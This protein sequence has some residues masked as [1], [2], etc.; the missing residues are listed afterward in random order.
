M[1]FWDTVL[2]GFLGSLAAGLILVLLYVV[3]QWF[4]NATDISISYSWIYKGTI[5]SATDFQPYFDIR[6][7]SKSNTYRLANITYS[8][9]GELQSIDNKSIWGTELPPGSIRF[10]QA[11]PVQSITSLSQCIEIEVTVRLQDGRSFW[12]RG[13]GPGQLRMGKFQSLLFELRKRICAAA[14][15]MQ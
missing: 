14:V 6:N 3:I 7:R 8:Q 10:L 4:L 11:D 12:L 15:P 1:G 13:Q 2:S 9:N 5:S